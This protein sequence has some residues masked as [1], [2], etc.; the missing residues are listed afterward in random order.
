MSVSKSAGQV[1]VERIEKWL[2]GY[3]VL[4]ADYALV[5]ALWS[6]M[7]WTFDKFDVIP[8]LAITAAVKRAGKTQLAE[9]VGRL[10]YSPKMFAAMTGPTFYRVL[11]Q[12]EGKLTIIFD[13][14]ESTSKEAASIMRSV[15]NVGFRKGQTIPRTVGSVVVEFPIYCPKAFVL[16]G[17]PNDTL[18][19]RSIVLTLE[20]AM[21]DE[22]SKL[23]DYD[24][25]V[26]DGE[27][28]AIVGD[29][30]GPALGTL[31]RVLGDTPAVM[32][33]RP[34]FLSGR[35]RDIWSAL[36]GLA[37]A[38]RLDDAMIDRLTRV[39]ADLAASKSAPA[40]RAR[41]EV[42]AGAAD[43]GYSERLIKDL[44][45]VLKDG[46][47][48]IFSVVAVERLKGLNDG[49]WRAFRGTGLDVQSLASLLERHGVRRRA[50]RLPR[51]AKGQPGA[52]AN[53][54]RAVDIEAATAKL[55]GG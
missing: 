45:R 2:G 33:V 5:C 55:G 48:A 46:E 20:R 12:N 42:E 40:R 27:A 15:L 47:K 14:A 51:A 49:P 52:L 36:F 34:A 7:S 28:A 43:A 19:D 9:L 37:A 30:N 24:M 32:A 29:V 6:V 44:R 4:P 50:L 54:Y 10:C 21:P 17:D 41:V 13:E 26:A 53:G 23:R 39:A 16:I 22:L 38:L 3:M 11:G 35:D 1:V 31:R 18:R 25:S 8:Y